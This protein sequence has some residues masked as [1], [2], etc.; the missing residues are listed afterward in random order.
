M[1][2]FRVSLAELFCFAFVVV[3]FRFENRFLVGCF[4]DSKG[5]WW[6]SFKGSVLCSSGILAVPLS[7][8]LGD[9]FHRMLIS[10]SIP[11]PSR[12]K[13]WLSLKCPDYWIPSMS[14]ELSKL[15]VS[16]NKLTMCECD[17]KYGS[18]LSLPSDPDTPKLELYSST[19][20]LMNLFSFYLC[21]LAAWLLL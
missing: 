7:S 15:S 21:Y 18:L 17:L 11:I 12:C 5:D 2:W 19:F 10:G 20:L 1:S 8:F 6:C 3:V 4:G 13:L 16:L 9:L 14:I